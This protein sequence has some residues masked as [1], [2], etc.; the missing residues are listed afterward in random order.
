MRCYGEH[1]AT[2]RLKPSKALLRKL[3]K[4]T[5][6]SKSVKLTVAVAME[7]LGGPAQTGEQDGHTALTRMARRTPL[8]GKVVLITGAARGIGAQTARVAAARGARLALA[9]LEPERLEA[10]AAE[11]GPGHAWFACDVTDQASVDAAVAG[12]VERLGG[13]DIVLA[14]AGIGANGTLAIAPVDV[15]LR[16]I[17]VNLNGV[18]RTVAAALPHVTDRRG[19]VMITASSASF[20]ALPGMTTYC[21][22]KA[23]V[24][25]FANSL[26]LEL[27][28][29]GVAV[30]TIHPAWI[31]TDLVRD[32]KQESELF[33]EAIAKLPGPAGAQVS[34]EECAEAIADGMERRRRKVFVPRGGVALSV[35]KPLITSAAV[36]WLPRRQ[37]RRAVPRLE[38]ET[39]AR[40]TWF[41]ATSMG[42]GE[43]ED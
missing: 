18:V 39:L 27:A 22:A 34:V 37:A 28:H 16:V 5:A 8:A 1:T 29:K 19:Y 10:L 31:D 36:D 15:L 21:A 7:D 33:D 42:M 11:L 38:A 35:L 4:G 14:N 43:K 13:I 12:T 25:H 32:Q 20:G 41:G 9:G 40:G 24:E 23:G 17:D 30:G 2:V 6:G 3:R 26:R